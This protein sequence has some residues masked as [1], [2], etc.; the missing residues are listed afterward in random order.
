[1]RYGISCE[2]SHLQVQEKTKFGPLTKKILV[3]SLQKHLPENVDTQ[4]LG[5]KIWADRQITY[6]VV[7]AHKGVKKQKTT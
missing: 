6:P 7:L 3:G 2:N 4:A 5:A 1:M